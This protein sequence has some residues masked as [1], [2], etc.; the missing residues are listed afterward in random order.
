[1][2][3]TLY[4]KEA[5]KY[6]EHAMGMFNKIKVDEILPQEAATLFE[7]I[8]LLQKSIGTL[9]QHNSIEVKIKK[10]KTVRFP[11]IKIPKVN[12]VREQKSVLPKLPKIKKERPVFDG[13]RVED[14]ANVISNTEFFEYLEAKKSE[15]NNK[16]WHNQEEVKEW[17]FIKGVQ[18]ID[19]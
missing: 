5:T 18:V 2:N 16:F 1:M 8:T 14:L 17:L 12:E 7:A 10:D 19:Y 11:K 4:I 3:N 9:R 13:I 6:M 15:S